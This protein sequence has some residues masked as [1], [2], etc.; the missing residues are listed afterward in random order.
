MNEETEKAY[1]E[2]IRNLSEFIVYGEKNEKNYFEQFCE[3]N[4][5]EH[6]ARILTL[7]NRQVNMQLI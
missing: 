7:N 1:V 5:L 6:F 4:I 2:V 3:M